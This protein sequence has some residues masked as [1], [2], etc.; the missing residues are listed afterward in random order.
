[1]IH[2]SFGDTVDFADQLTKEQIKSNKSVDLTIRQEQLLHIYYDRSV[3]NYETA[4]TTIEH[5]L[6]EVTYSESKLMLQYLKAETNFDLGNYKD[7]MESIKYILDINPNDSHTE[8]LKA[9]TE[10][11]SGNVNEALETLKRFLAK[12][13]DAD[14]DWALREEATE[15]REKIELQPLSMAK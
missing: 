13:Y 6:E 12:T 9:N 7:A 10:F 5:L 1:M 3:G 15:L 4:L 11:R 14:P 8:L 2:K